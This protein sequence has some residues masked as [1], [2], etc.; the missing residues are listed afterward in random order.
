MITD[1]IRN[2]ITSIMN[3]GN[4]V[5]GST[6]SLIGDMKDMNTSS[7]SGIAET[8]GIPVVVVSMVSFIIYK[9]IKSVRL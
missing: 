5:S 3:L 2:L 6:F 4:E 9:L 1:F 8:I 7:M